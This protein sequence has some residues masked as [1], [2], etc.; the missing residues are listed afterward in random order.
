MNKT[1]IF[2][3]ADVQAKSC[4]D[5]EKVDLLD[6]GPGVEEWWMEWTTV[7]LDLTVSTGPEIECTGFEK[8]GECGFVDVTVG[9]QQADQIVL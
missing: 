8:K 1:E 3:V 4:H 9:F 6:L 5:D 7:S 2:T